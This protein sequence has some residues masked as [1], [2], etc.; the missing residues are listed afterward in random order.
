LCGGCHGSVSGAELDV[1]ANPDILTSASDVAALDPGRGSTDLS[2]IV[3]APEGP[4]F[5]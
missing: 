3:G 1:V 2:I 5:P 4:D